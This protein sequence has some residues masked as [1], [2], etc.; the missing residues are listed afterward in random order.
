LNKS[1]FSAAALGETKFMTIPFR[2]P[3]LKEKAQYNDLL[4]VRLAAFHIVNIT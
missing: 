1:S 3:L 4:L 2:E